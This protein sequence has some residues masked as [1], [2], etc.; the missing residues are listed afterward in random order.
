MRA[1]HY[2]FQSGIA[3]CLLIILAGCGGGINSGTSSVPI[4]SVYSAN[5]WRLRQKETCQYTIVLA[6]YG[7][8]DRVGRAQELRQLA[9]SILRSDDIWLE[10]SQHWL[11]VNYGHFDTFKAAKKSLKRVKKLYPSLQAGALQFCFVSEVPEPDPPAPANW[12][13][14]ENSC[15]YSL[16]IGTYYNVPEEGY[17]DRKRD[18]V[19]AVESLRRSGAQ[20]YFI[21]G[22]NESRV[23]VGCLPRSAALPGIRRAQTVKQLDPL[24]QVT[25]SKYSSRFENGIQMNSI[26]SDTQGNTI[27]VGQKPILI[28]VDSLREEVTF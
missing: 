22:H 3:V 9:K 1:Y 10:N 2:I 17:L 25:L 28:Y 5:N 13:L 20:A 4:A 8:F 14:L 27:K 18:A 24:V 26:L 12:N 7:Q 16:E 19:K 21:H 11:S 23:Y 6:Q 15:Y